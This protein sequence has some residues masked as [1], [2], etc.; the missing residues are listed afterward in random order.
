MIAYAKT[1]GEII[2]VVN[3][4]V[5]APVILVLFALAL[6]LFFWGVLEFILNT[7]NEEKRTLG[8]SHMLWGIIGLVIMVAVNGIIQ[9]LINFV[10]QI[11]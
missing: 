3:S 4:D 9:I 10:S 1:V 2:G 6:V 7:D 8:K 5:L 11:K